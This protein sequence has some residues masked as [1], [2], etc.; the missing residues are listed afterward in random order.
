LSTFSIDTTENPETIK[1]K[2]LSKSRLDD[3]SGA[4][5]YVCNLPD[6]FAPRP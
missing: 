2:T 1:L 6:L 3:Q 5:I 4:D